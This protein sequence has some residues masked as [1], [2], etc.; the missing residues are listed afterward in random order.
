MCHLPGIRGWRTAFRRIDRC[1]N[2]SAAAWV[3]T[4]RSSTRTSAWKTSCRAKLLAKA[5]S[6]SRVGRIGMPE[7][8]QVRPRPR[9]S[10]KGTQPLLFGTAD[11][12]LSN[13]ATRLHLVGLGIAFGKLKTCR[14][15]GQHIPRRTGLWPSPFLPRGAGSLIWPLDKK[16]CRGLGLSSWNTSSTCTLKNFQKA[17]IWARATISRAWLPKGRTIQEA[18]EIARDVAKKL[19][20]QKSSADDAAEDRLPEALDRFDY[21]LVVAT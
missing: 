9:P 16:A 17:S 2:S 5:N 15:G 6:R 12:G 21:P 20:E 13:A 14:H 18:L 10:K 1:I 19:L 11:A 4:S 8:E 3:F 7:E